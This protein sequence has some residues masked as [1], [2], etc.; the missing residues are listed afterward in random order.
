MILKR[1][2]RWTHAK[3]TRLA[4]GQLEPL[5]ASSR[6]LSFKLGGLRDRARHLRQ[7]FGWP[8]RAK[9]G[10]PITHEWIDPWTLLLPGQHRWAQVG[11]TDE[12]REFRLA[13]SRQDK[14]LERA[15]PLITHL[16]LEGNSVAGHQIATNFCP[17]HDSTAVLSCTN[18]VAITILKSRWEWN[19]ISIELE[20]RWKNRSWN[21]A[22]GV[23]LLCEWAHF[24]GYFTHYRPSSEMRL[25]CRQ[26]IHKNN[27]DN[28]QKV[29]DKILTNMVVHSIT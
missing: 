21:G 22:Q 19:E 1:L 5:A 20:L 12:P 6:Q 14:R 13:G 26:L 3:L 25:Y 24:W 9:R 18:F 17:C 29:I 11:A 27:N 10:R 7:Y 15:I 8:R 2:Y 16:C 28:F 23:M 4:A